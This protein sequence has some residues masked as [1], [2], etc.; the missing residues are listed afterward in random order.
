MS[1][2]YSFPTLMKA[3]QEANADTYLYLQMHVIFFLIE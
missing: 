1:T 3:F 2:N